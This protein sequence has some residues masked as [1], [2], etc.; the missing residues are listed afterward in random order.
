MAT[1]CVAQKLSRLRLMH[2]LRAFLDT[3]K[4]PSLAHAP[5]DAALAV[6][7]DIV[8][9]AE[10]LDTL[11]GNCTG[12]QPV[13]QAQSADCL[14]AMRRFHRAKRHCLSGRNAFS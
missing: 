1:L 9:A 14:Y 10:G 12:G 7:Q 13:G 11:L 8:G 4:K 5:R 6:T 2:V 3:G